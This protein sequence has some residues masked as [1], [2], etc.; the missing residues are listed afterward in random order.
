MPKR[1]LNNSIQAQ[2]PSYEEFCERN[3]QRLAQEGITLAQPKK[4]APP[5]VVSRR[6]WKVS[7]ALAT[8]CVAVLVG[9]FALPTLFAGNSVA[10]K[11][12]PSQDSEMGSTPPTEQTPTKATVLLRAENN[13]P[14]EAEAARST[15]LWKA[16]CTTISSR[17]IP[18]FP[19]SR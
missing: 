17:Y 13:T 12:P 5:T 4:P 14:P 7:A 16:S 18:C 19:F 1:K 8:V 11:P 2:P 3:A 9:V 15:T 6:F 10:P